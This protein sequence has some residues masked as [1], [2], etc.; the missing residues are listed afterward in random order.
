M[1]AYSDH[2]ILKIRV[3]G[4]E[5]RHQEGDFESTRGGDT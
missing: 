2:L 5:S 1:A 4:Y 3:K